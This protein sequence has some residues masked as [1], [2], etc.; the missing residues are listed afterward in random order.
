MLL[1]CVLLCFELCFCFVLCF[2]IDYP[3]PFGVT[4]KSSS[5]PI[6]QRLK[7]HPEKERENC[8]PSSSSSSSPSLPGNCPLSILQQRKPVSGDL[9]GHLPG[10]GRGE[11]EQKQIKGGG[12]GEIPLPSSSLPPLPTPWSRLLGFIWRPSRSGRNLEVNLNSSLCMFFLGWPTTPTREGRDNSATPEDK[13]NNP[14]EGP[15]PHSKRGGGSPTTRR[16]R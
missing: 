9:K 14:Q 11:K 16:K 10:R 8:L 3:T 6:V 15:T 5:N 12:G 1:C 4:F 13:R 7:E 2:A